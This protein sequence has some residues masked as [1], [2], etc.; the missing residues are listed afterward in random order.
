MMY[1]Y[2]I[3]ID[4]GAAPNPYY[5]YCTLV[6]CKPKIRKKANFGDWVMGTG[7]RDVGNNKIVYAMKV[8]EIMDFQHYFN[9]KRFQKKIPTFD[10][11]DEFC[12]LGDNIYKPTPEGFKQLP[13]VHSNNKNENV[14]NKQH[15]LGLNLEKNRVLISDDFY[16]FGDKAI[17]LPKKLL[18]LTKKGQAHKSL[19]ISDEDIQ[20]LEEFISGYTKGIN[21]KPN[22]LL[23]P[24]Q[25]LDTSCIKI[26]KCCTE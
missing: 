6:I 8:T 9:D 17:E 11:R 10:K 3:D 25:V 1:S 16:Y 23:T 18:N 26:D 13:S 5:G 14:K 7:N 21:G 15:D 19:S 2:V 24:E 12:H 4:D 22:N 20:E